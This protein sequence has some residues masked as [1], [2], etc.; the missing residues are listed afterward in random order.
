MKA[1]QSGNGRDN[2]EADGRQ[3]TLSE[4]IKLFKNKIYNRLED[5]FHLSNKKAL[6]WNMSQYYDSKGQNIDDALPRTFHIDHGI[7]DPEYQKFLRY[8]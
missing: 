3:M 8:H 6:F 4:E 5:N 7:N 1:E 2:E